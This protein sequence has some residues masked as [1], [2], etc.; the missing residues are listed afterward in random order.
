MDNAQGDNG[1]Q[2]REDVVVCDE[3]CRRIVRMCQEQ[4]LPLPEVGYGLMDAAGGGC[5]EAELAW[6]SKKVA[7]LL[8]EQVQHEE[9]FSERDWTAF[10]AASLAND[11]HAECLPWCCLDQ[12]PRTTWVPP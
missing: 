6:P 12:S 2:E 9:R 4:H 11:T 8:P 7:V 3:R 5:A 10:A 1:K